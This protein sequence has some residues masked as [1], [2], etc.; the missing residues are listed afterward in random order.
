MWPPQSDREHHGEEDTERW[1]RLDVTC[2]LCIALY[3]RY[4][5]GVDHNDQRY[6]VRLKNMK[7]YKYIFWFL[8]DVSITNAFILSSFDVHRG[9]LLDHDQFV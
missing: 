8:F 7:C 4:M 1:T 2:P 6:H 3:N 9:A 5:G